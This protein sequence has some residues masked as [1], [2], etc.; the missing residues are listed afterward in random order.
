MASLVTR[1]SVIITFT[2][3]TVKEGR[4]VMLRRGDIVYAASP[5]RTT[6]YDGS[7]FVFVAKRQDQVSRLTASDMILVP[8][9]RLMRLTSFS[10]SPSSHSASPLSSS[11]SH[12]RSNDRY[13]SSCRHCGHA[14]HSRSSLAS[15]EL[16]CTKARVTKTYKCPICEQV[17]YT[18]GSVSIHIDT[19]HRSSSTPTR[20]PAT[21]P[22]ASSIDHTCPICNKTFFLAFTLNNHLDN[23][24]APSPPSPR[25]PEPEPEPKP[26]LGPP[27]L[28]TAPESRTDEP[29]P[30]REPPP[31]Q[32]R[33]QSQSPPQPDRPPSFRDDELQRARAAGSKIMRASESYLDPQMS[34][35]PLV[36]G[37]TVIVPRISAC[38]PGWLWVRNAANRAGYVPAMFVDEVAP[39]P[40]SSGGASSSS[41]RPRCR[42]CYRV[43][44]SEAQLASHEQHYHPHRLA[45][46]QK[47]MQTSMQTGAP[48]LAPAEFAHEL[49]GPRPAAALAAEACDGDGIGDDGSVTAPLPPPI[50]LPAAAAVD[51]VALGMW[52]GIQGSNNSCYLDAT[53]FSLFVTVQD[54]DVMLDESEPIRLRRELADSPDHITYVPHL[55]STLRNLVVR[56]LRGRLFVDASVM[57]R[58]RLFLNKVWD[59]ENDPTVGA[60]E[61]EDVVDFITVLFNLL[62]PDDK[63]APGYVSSEAVDGTILR[64]FVHTLAPIFDPESGAL[65]TFIGR[66]PSV[67]VLLDAH[68][69]T[70]GMVFVG[71]PKFLI[72]QMPR[73]YHSAIYDFIYPCGEVTV[74]V[75]HPETGD[76]SLARL[77][78][79]AIIC[80]DSSHFVAY[81]RIPVVDADGSLAHI[82]VRFDSMGD[83][84]ADHG[85]VPVLHRANN[86]ARALAEP[87]S[88]ATLVDSEL[89]AHRGP[90][91]YRYTDTR[92]SVDTKRVL[93]DGYALGASCGNAVVESGE[94]C[95][96]GNNDS[97]DGCSAVCVREYCGDGIL[98]AYNVSNLS[99]N[100][101]IFSDDFE[102]GTISAAWQATGVAIIGNVGTCA[103]RGSW[104]ARFQGDSVRTLQLVGTLEKVTR[105]S[106]DVFMTSSSGSCENPDNGEDLTLEYKVASGTTWTILAAVPTTHSTWSSHSIDI[107]ADVQGKIIHLRFNQAS[108]SGSSFDHMV[109]DDVAIY[110]GPAEP[111]ECDDGTPDATSVD[112]CVECRITPYCGDGVVN[113]NVST[114]TY[115]WTFATHG[116]G[117][118]WT[119]G[120][121]ARIS[122][123]CAQESITF[124][125][126][127]DRTA[128]LTIDTLTT[129][130]GGIEV[131][132][133]YGS[134]VGSCEKVD[135]G[136]DLHATFKIRGASVEHTEI[137]PRHS[138]SLGTHQLAIPASMQNRK[139]TDAPFELIFSQPVHSG[140]SYDV[141]ALVGVNIVTSLSAEVCDDGNAFTNDSCVL[142][143]PARCGDGLVWI[144]VEA[145]D[146]A[147]E[148]ASC[149]VDCT[150]PVCGDGIRNVAAGEEC[151]DGSI[152]CMPNCRYAYCGDGMVTGSEA[153]DSGSP[154]GSTT[155]TPN[156]TVHGGCGDGVINPGAGEECDDGNAVDGDGC[157]ASCTWEE[158]G[159]GSAASPVFTSR[160][161][162]GGFFDSFST[163]S[164]WFNRYTTP[165]S[166]AVV[167]SGCTPASDPSTAVLLSSNGQRELELK[168]VTGFAGMS[169]T[170]WTSGVARSAEAA[171]DARC[172]VVVSNT[173]SQLLHVAART[174]D[175]TTGA[176]LS[177]YVEVAAVSPL[178]SSATSFAETVVYVT[179]QAVG[180]TG[181]SLDDRARRIGVQIK[182]YRSA[183][184]VGGA[185][186]TTFVDDVEVR[187]MLLR[188]CDDGN[189]NPADGCSSCLLPR[190]GDFV[191]NGVEEC[192]SGGA[193][194]GY[195]DVDCTFPVC[196]DGL[197]NP[198]STGE[199]C[200]D[201]NTIN[202]DSCV[203]CR[204][205]SCGDGFVHQG[206]EPC[207]ASAPNSAPCTSSCTLPVCGD[208]VVTSPEECDDGN[209]I[210]SDGCSN[211]CRAPRC[212]NGRVE[213]S[214]H[215]FDLRIPLSS[216]SAVADAIGVQFYPATLPSCL[217]GS[218]AKAG[219]TVLFTGTPSSG[220][221]R[222]VTLLPPGTQEVTFDVRYPASSTPCETVDSGELL[223]VQLF[224]S[225]QMS[226]SS[227]IGGTVTISRSSTSWKSAVV[228]L[229]Q[230]SG[231]STGTPAPLFLVFL[232]TKQSATGVR[233]EVCDEGGVHTVSCDADCTAPSCGDGMVNAAAGEECDTAVTSSLFCSPTCKS[234]NVVCG[235]GVVAP[236]EDCDTGRVATSQ[237]D[238]DCTFAVCGDGYVNSAA[239]EECDSTAACSSTCRISG[240]NSTSSSSTTAGASSRS[241]SG[242]SS[243]TTPVVAIA[244]GLAGTLLLLVIIMV[245]TKRQ[246]M[247]RR[248]GVHQARQPRPP[249][250][251]DE[252]I[253]LPPMGSGAGMPPPPPFTPAGVMPPVPGSSPLPPSCPAAY[254]GPPGSAFN[255]AIMPPSYEAVVSSPTVPPPTYGG[256]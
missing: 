247:A 119:L 33:L 83:A 81:N 234:I 96:D 198:Y 156:C 12:A 177:S 223:V 53:L 165:L 208:G 170:T 25:E 64:A 43:Y 92:V 154:L 118:E 10:S 136:E 149:N 228:S 254:F 46:E 124:D 48:T 139:P 172:G 30:T 174:V 67:Q 204:P 63:L 222:L 141:S 202:T 188:E 236:G 51:R 72:L 7:T 216:T 161:A 189:T 197:V 178:L 255:T 24:H 192:D 56:D 209:A 130:I 74:P 50:L 251:V 23:E 90:K 16:Y 103:A 256:R 153:C 185:D 237:C 99:G 32:P 245:V 19:F 22:V 98:N 93:A 110:G 144:G 252:G 59:A 183:D 6:C 109:L 191:V 201:G 150:A 240:I 89:A 162:H 85:S 151:D 182:L 127:S 193:A 125:G 26:Q 87:V 244:G 58:F 187:A 160:A 21:E 37:E 116:L 4:K 246:Q 253:P 250:G 214:S 180:M 76:D 14:S 18:E 114:A 171:S 213:S 75:R 31:A 91:A 230:F 52:R 195:C 44:S 221:R 159:D 235:D 117:P 129:R 49:Y 29:T 164:E 158:C 13:G 71:A 134:G 243:S 206:I 231:W 45:H 108:S 78:L 120:T 157:S 217:V 145:C 79:H 248:R 97:Y 82:W 106:F 41:I 227:Q 9:S 100:R 211:S 69:A 80:I 249:P 54:F 55:R 17:F 225:A 175:T 179:P 102:S 104:A 152:E 107:P 184:S 42:F 70:Y 60:C 126:T 88:L 5:P 95:D 155:C 62:L 181:Y 143:A 218:S 113:G 212:G 146:T 229:T 135:S 239:G 220:K 1:Y 111:E 142:C 15:H 28:G 3:S 207:D 36:K 133:E 105:V 20:A 84:S 242:S 68:L 219:E 86:L 101:L 132:Y 27:G 8:E 128:T 186:P 166:N 123:T 200:D 115:E 233:S 232:Q 65:E 40:D 147:G 112:G 38:R 2:G 121:G 138:G 11:R 39:E 210:D 196:G 77:D 122:S 34:E 194:T 137:L 215:Q 66:G 190:C 199:V 140:S 224:S 176:L 203:N 131:T 47:T 94:E 226:S 167:Q 205:A 169:F 35:L 57:L 163:T 238:P 61:E 148:S 168:P 241:S 73:E 173:T